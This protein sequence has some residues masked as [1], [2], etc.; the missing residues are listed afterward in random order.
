MTFTPNQ[1]RIAS[2]AVIALVCWLLLSMLA[3]VLM[4]FLLAVGLAY[5]L[6][7]LVQWLY[8]R[9]VPRWL[10]AGLAI[11]TLM[12]VLAAVFLLIVPVITK[13]VPLLKEQVPLLLD[14]INEFLLPL[15]GRFGIDLQ[16]DVSQVRDWL[17]KLIAEHESD[18]IGGLLSSLRIGGSA[19]A[20]VFGNLVLA[21]IVAYYLLLDW[22]R[23]IERTKG[24]IPPRWRPNVQ[25]FLNDTDAVLG[26]YMRGQ[27]VV[28]GFLAILY[29]AGLALVGLELAWPIGVFTG[30]AV[31]VPYLGFGLG[32]I[33][34]VL[35]AV[36]QF[37]SVLGVALVALV[38]VVGQVVESV[39]VTPRLL[40]NRIGLH[41]I[42]VIFALM[43]FG[44][45]FGFV[46]VLIALPTSAVL[47]VAIRRAKDSYLKSA[48][49][50]EA[51]AA[52][53]PKRIIVN[54]EDAQ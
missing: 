30:L 38:F 44:Q 22:A 48:L 53:T 18:L 8:T 51:S 5:V 41:P 19:L 2:W 24:L 50:L 6:Q 40:G 45:L 42:A 26:Q 23:L 11:F 34:G 20:A 35:A 21:P 3:P 28:M 1:I 46:G 47:L 4:P 37:Q 25:G 27:V 14:R 10:G 33:M 32:M 49:Y 12:L 54:S 52:D 9:R 17:R 16:I 15:A 7:P 13:Q 31:F 36:L 39:Y 29:T 43:A